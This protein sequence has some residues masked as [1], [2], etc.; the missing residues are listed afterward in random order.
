MSYD[1]SMAVN[2]NEEPRSLAVSDKLFNRNYLMLYQGQF[3]SRLGNAVYSLA[4]ALWL[5][6][7]TDSGTVMGIFYAVTAFPLIAMSVIGGAVAD[8]F[9]RKGII[10]GTD[11]LNGL[12]MLA[13]AGVL[14]M[15]YSQP[16]QIAAVFIV[17]IVASSLRAF[18][19]PAANAAI[20]DLVPE[21]RIEG[22]NSMG[23]LSEKISQFFGSFSGAYFLGLLGLPLLVA[24]NGITYLLSALSE[25][26]IHIPQRIPEK[27]KGIKNYFHIFSEDIRQGLRYIRQNAGLKRLLYLSI[28]TSFF[29]T[30]V[31]ILMVFYVTDFLKLSNEWFGYFLVIFG[32]GSLVGT[33]LVS[34]FRVHGDSRKFFLILFLLLEAAGY[35]LLPYVTHYS[36]AMA[37][38]FF[39]G[40]MNGFSTIS[41][42]SLMQLTTPSKIRGRVFG[43]LT[44]LSGS[45]AP[46]GMAMGGVLYDY[47][48]HNIGII[49]TISGLGMIFVIL[50]VSSN[51]A[52]RKF[53][54]YETPEQMG[55]TGF[56]YTI[57]T[58]QRD[59]LLEQKERFIEEQFKKTRSQI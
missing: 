45:I 29:S 36:Q 27:T 44:T 55:A 37:L 8:R 35:L 38:A 43:A 30:P 17:G 50:I 4:I 57:K 31:M 24:I 34:V 18:F 5:K 11:V 10:V 53:I 33:I 51:R 59:Q 7:V 58:V 41:I 22:A 25:G 49:Y 6:G 48:D 21:N 1:N 20:P 13:L 2:S 9:S 28:G 19:G 46:L 15:D 47:F 3:V 14:W 16:V 26:F 39:G 12:A 40:V 32:V 56:R 42:F 52:F 23:K 54:A